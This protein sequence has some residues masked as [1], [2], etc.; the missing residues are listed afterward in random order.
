MPQAS[1]WPYRHA[2]RGADS[3][4]LQ[5][6]GRRCEIGG[7]DECGTEGRGEWGDPGGAEWLGTWLGTRLGTRRALSTHIARGSE[8]EQEHEHGA[9]AASRGLDSLHARGSLHVMKMRRGRGARQQRTSGK[10]RATRVGV[11]LA[12]LTTVVAC[13]RTL[14]VDAPPP[15]VTADVADSLLTLPPSVVESQIRYELSPA[16]QALERAVPTTFGD[17]NKRLDVQSNRRVHV[18][19]AA[20]RSPFVISV[21]SQRVTVS[22]VVEYEGQIG[23]ASCRERV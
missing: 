13:D 15:D 19:F 9:S 20:K 16:L 14:N 2:K 12:C 4:Q 1:V 5:H 8:R 11:A 6:P 10:G 22:S 3:A 23:R 17:I 7:R 18:A 21:D